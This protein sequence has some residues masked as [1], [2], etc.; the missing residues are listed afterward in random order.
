MRRSSCVAMIARLAVL[1]AVCVLTMGAQSSCSS[2]GGEGTLRVDDPPVSTGKGTRNGPT[3][4][5]TLALKDSSGRVTSRFSRGEL[6]TFE[7]SV[8]NRTSAPIRLQLP[9]MGGNQD[10]QVFEPGA[11]ESEWDWVA[12]KSF[13]AVVTEVIFEAGGTQVFTGTWDQVK[14]D[15]A[16]LQAGTHEAF[17]RFFPIPGQGLALTDDDTQS[18]RVRFMV[19]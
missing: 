4:S 12:N 15:G 2:N 5:V 9:T 1:G 6:I 3:F 8:L 18:P 7:L 16:M 11:T 13:P 17:G 14:L 19:N 10:F